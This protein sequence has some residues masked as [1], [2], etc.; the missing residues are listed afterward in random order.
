MILVHDG[1]KSHQENFK[2]QKHKKDNVKFARI[3]ELTIENNFGIT[4]Y[5][6]IIKKFNNIF[7]LSVVTFELPRVYFPNVA[8][9]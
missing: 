1:K 4:S 8:A 3:T 5:V 2:G 7:F 6:Q 9:T